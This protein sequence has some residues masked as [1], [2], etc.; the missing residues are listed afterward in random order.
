MSECQYCV[1]Y[2]DRVIVLEAERDRLK[3]AMEWKY[4]AYITCREEIDRLKANCDS[5]IAR[6]Q[7]IGQDRDLW[8]SKCEDLKSQADKLSCPICGSDVDGKNWKSR[9]E[10]LFEAGKK[11]QE[12][13]GPLNKKF[14][15]GMGN[16]SIMIL[17]HAKQYDEWLEALAEF[18]KGGK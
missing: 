16:Q 18:E 8:K 1:A 14:R 12:M 4:K 11:L 15:T 2:Q 6:V 13:L 10:K 9:A 5:Y 17:A 3:D 7:Q